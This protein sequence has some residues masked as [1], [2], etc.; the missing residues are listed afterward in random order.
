MN[1]LR[2]LVGF[3]RLLRLQGLPVGTGR[4]LTFYRAVGALEPVTRE[5]LYWAARSSLVSNHQQFG[6]FD[7][8]FAAY[9]KDPVVQEITSETA[10]KDGDTP[11]AEALDIEHSPGAWVIP[12]EDEKLEGETAVSVVASAAEILKERSFDELT[13]EEL[14]QVAVLIRNLRIRVPQRRV[15]RARR[16]PRGR[17]FDLRRTLRYSLRTEGEPFRR[18]WMAKTRRARPLVLLLDV[19]GSMTP[20]ASALLQFG[21]AAMAAGHKVEVF[22]FGT[23]LTRITRALRSRDPSEALSKVFEMVQDAEG[24]TRI[25]DSLD[26]LIR[27]YGQHGFLRGSVVVLCSD[28]LERGNPKSLASAMRRLCRIVHRM[29]WVNPLKGSPRYQPLA[30]GMAAALPHVDVFLPGHNLASLEAL[31]RILDELQ[32]PRTGRLGRTQPI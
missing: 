24:G 13:E 26:E 19:S 17:E 7:E 30:Q 21:F 20:Y 11:E 6:L 18:A 1:V 10:P 2:L 27:R 8:A 9:F 22:C 32:D 28:G 15:R 31:G 12:D 4:I 16:A 3:G 14:H 29:V 5:G 23:R 25:G